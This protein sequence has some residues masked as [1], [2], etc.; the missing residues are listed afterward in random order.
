M[1][2]KRGKSRLSSATKRARRF[3]KKYVVDALTKRPKK[4]LPVMYPQLKEALIE[5]DYL[6]TLLFDKYEVLGIPE[7][8]QPYY[9]AWAKQKAEKGLKLS[10]ET[11]IAEDSILHDEFVLRGLDPKWLFELELTVDDWL[12]VEKQGIVNKRI[13]YLKCRVDSV[14]VAYVE[15]LGNTQHLPPTDKSLG[16]I[17]VTEQTYTLKSLDISSF[18]TSWSELNNFC[19]HLYIKGTS[20]ANCYI[21]YAYVIAGF[22]TH[23][24][25]VVVNNFSADWNMWTHTGTFPWLDK[26]D[27]D[28]HSIYGYGPPYGLRDAYFDFTDV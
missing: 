2:R 19:I 3:K 17:M 4:L 7:D 16:T 5:W 9:T 21:T 10:E 24:R 13:L 26:D 15:V 1:V 23:A 28:I 25:K 12:E 6:E 27:G 20:T 18:I 8:E 22:N 11:K 14:G